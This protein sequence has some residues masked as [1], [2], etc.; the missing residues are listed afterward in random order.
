M[1]QVLKV[2][3][4]GKPFDSMK[5]YACRS[6]EETDELFAEKKDRLLNV[7][8]VADNGAWGDAP[9]VCDAFGHT[10]VGRKDNL[11]FEIVLHEGA[12]PATTEDLHRMHQQYLSEKRELDSLIGR[13]MKW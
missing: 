6:D 12:G 7:K 4:E 11:V 2:D 3:N 9:N 8:P 1:A 13:I 5:I 10:F